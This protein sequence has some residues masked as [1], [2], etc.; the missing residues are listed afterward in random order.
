MNGMGVGDE[1][2]AWARVLAQAAVRAGA[3]PGALAGPLSAGLLLP[4][5]SRADAVGVLAVVWAADCAALSAPAPVGAPPAG[6]GPRSVLASGVW[7]S[8]GR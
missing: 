4:E 5:P 6:T 8:R 2:V 1:I 3:G 7:A